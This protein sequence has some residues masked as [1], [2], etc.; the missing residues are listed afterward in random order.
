MSPKCFWFEQP[1]GW[2]YHEPYHTY[3]Y[4][5]EGCGWRRLE[6]ED[7]EFSFGQD[8]YRYVIDIQV[9]RLSRRLDT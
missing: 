8:E 9:G 7:Q 2:S 3:G 5:R 1:K 6:W 4:H